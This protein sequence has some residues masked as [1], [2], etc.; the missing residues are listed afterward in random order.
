M[1]AN[2]RGV[3]T[4]NILDYGA[5]G[6]G[7]T[8]NTAAIQAAIDACAADDGGTVLVPAGRFLTGML[9]LKSNV[10]LHLAQTAVLL[11]S[12][13]L[14][15][16]ATDIAGCGFDC[17]EIDKVLIYAEGV[18]NVKIDG[19]GRIDG[20]GGSFPLR[21]PD[22][23]V[24]ER[25]MLTRFVD[26][27]HIVF[28]D[29][30]LGNAGAWCSH[31]LRC[32][33]VRV[34]GVNIHNRVNHNNDGIDL[35]STENVRI[36]DCSIICEDDAICFQPM[37]ESHHV[38]DIVI[39]NCIMSTRWAAIRS[40]CALGGIANVTVSNCVIYDTYGCG[41][42][43]Q[44]NGNAVMEDMT[45]SNIVMKNVSA[46][47][48][49]HFGSHQFNNLRRDESKPWGALRN[50]MFSNIRANVLDEASLRAGLPSL[51]EGTGVPTFCEGEQKN[52]ITIHGIAG[53]PVE[54][55]SLSDISVTFPG[56]GTAEDAANL[57]SPEHEDAY[58]EYF[59]W[60]VL[61]AYGLY[62]RHAR[63]ITLNNVRFE[64]ESPDA[65]PAVVLDDVDG[66]DAYGFRADLCEGVE[67]LIKTRATTGLRLQG[68]R[69]IGNEE[70]PLTTEF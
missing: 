41:I 46:P 61:P 3:T 16:Y 30:S 10:R 59:A 65:R 20:Q 66:L 43:L 44:M 68:C 62:A 31:F 70:A 64:L 38:K 2:A 33:D 14:D 27:R 19:R 4:F 57:N 47:I 51:Y 11:G 22:G 13:N 39:T 28:E 7:L 29:V 8:L 36:S 52:G 6:D 23:S 58:P 21:N 35:M 49:L 1:A 34:T 56:G 54:N 50:I 69:S 63:G 18:E 48:G 32:S 40:G 9:R 5:V 55:I 24:G 17:E 60:G 45:F 67:A 37:S 15:D 26:S 42:K 53:H 12:T 25:P